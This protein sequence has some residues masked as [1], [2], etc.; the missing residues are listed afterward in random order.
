[1]R[2]TVTLNVITDLQEIIEQTRVEPLEE[3]NLGY[4][5]SSARHVSAMCDALGVMLA[6]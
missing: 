5:R 1:M 2:V 6:R 3:L 4:I